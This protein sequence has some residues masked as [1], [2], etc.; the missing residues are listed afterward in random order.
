MGIRL[1]L[2]LDTHVV[3]WLALAPEK[4]S[5]RA[6]AAIDG[7]RQANAGLF[8]AGVTLVE[9]AVMFVRGRLQLH[10]PFN[11]FL[12]EVDRSFNVLPI[13]RHIATQ[14][15]QLP[16]AYPR[17]PMDRIIGATAIVQ[18]IPLVTA[19]DRIRKSAVLNTIW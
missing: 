14:V 16:A 2:L 1:M 12:E 3:A 6:S 7:A 13:D 5:Q 19:D 10:V 8:V 4:V 9:L 17:D 15:T 11:A 18:G